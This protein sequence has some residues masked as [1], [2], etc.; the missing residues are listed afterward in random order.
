MYLKIPKQSITRMEIVQTDCKMSLAQVVA[1]Y[2]PKY[3]FNGGLY[4]MD[5]GELCP[6]PLRVNG[7][8]LA[9]SKDGYWMMAW[10]KGPDLCMIHSRDM[11]KWKYAIACAAMLK[12]GAHT[13]FKPDGGMNWVRG[14]TGFG[15]DRDN[16]HVVVTTD[17]NGA[18]SPATLRR[19]MQSNGAQ[20]AIMLDSGGSS[21][22][23]ANGKYYQAEK[24]KVANWVLIWTEEEKEDKPSTSTAT[25]KKCPYVEPTSNVKNGT[26]G[27]GA[28]WTQWHLNEV[29][30][31]GLVVDGIFGTKSVAAL[32]NF[33]RS[34]GL[35]A[36][37]ICGKLSRAKLKEKL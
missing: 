15:D 26:R 6:I 17:T 5:T 32:K 22:L 8:T 10:N 1:K 16:A 13:I 2:K 25:K 11:E 28:K 36:D 14:R 35:V 7:K 33:Q 4:D 27:N 24:R 21:Q 19:T 23:Y 3:A 20:N 12:D 29:S 37:G 30:K 18:M 9:T 34:N 31:A